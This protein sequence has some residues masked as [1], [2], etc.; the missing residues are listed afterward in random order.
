MKA[1]TCYRL[2][3]IYIIAVIIVNREFPVI[4]VK[5]MNNMMNGYV[6]IFEPVIFLKNITGFSGLFYT[7]KQKYC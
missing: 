2:I 7:S 3:A 6:G 5:E 4:I 1:Y